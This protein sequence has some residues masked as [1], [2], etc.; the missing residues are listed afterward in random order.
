MT[1]SQLSVH[2]APSLEE[3][4]TNGETLGHYLRSEQPSYSNIVQVLQTVESQDAT[5]WK[6]LLTKGCAI[7][8]L[9]TK[10]LLSFIGFLTDLLDIEEL[11]ELEAAHGMFSY[12]LKDFCPPTVQI[13][14]IDSK[15]G[16]YQST[17]HAVAERTIPDQ[18][19]R[20]AGAKTRNQLPRIMAVQVWPKPEDEASLRSLVQKEVVAA[21]ILIGDPNGQSG[22]STNFDEFVKNKNYRKFQLPIKQICFIDTVKHATVTVADQGRSQVTMYLNSQIF[23]GFSEAGFLDAFGYES[24]LPHYPPDVTDKLVLQDYVVD[25]RIPPWIAALDGDELTKAIEI[26]TSVMKTPAIFDGHIPS[27]VKNMKQLQFWN[28]Q[29]T[30]LQ[31]PLI[32]DEN[33]EAWYIQLMNLPELGL[34][35]YRSTYNMPEYITTMKQAEQWLWARF[36]QKIAPPGWDASTLSLRTRFEQLWNIAQDERT[37]KCMAHRAPQGRAAGGAQGRNESSPIESH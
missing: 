18:I 15:P 25:R 20:F 11:I 14:A 16:I 28:S 24:F 7:Q 26:V 3:A 19:L 21:L 10:E 9:P 37:V 35:H 31:Y 5:T 22:I 13:N 29:C 8:E 17:Y 6:E 36:S 30:K 33:F 12:L 1:S 23:P 34:V 2:I 27:T 4:L 32:Q